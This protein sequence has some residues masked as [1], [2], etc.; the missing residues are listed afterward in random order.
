MSLFMLQWIDA[1]DTVEKWLEATIIAVDSDFIFVHYNG[2]A[3]R[4]DEWI[5][6][7]PPF[8]RFYLE[9]P[10]GRPLPDPHASRASPIHAQSGRGLLGT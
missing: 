5:H 8:L 10:A 6:V 3:T 1:L 7:V 9:F 4:W 2:W